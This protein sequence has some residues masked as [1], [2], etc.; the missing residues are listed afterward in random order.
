M[1]ESRVD[2]IDLNFGC[3]VR[4]IISKGGGAAV[5][6][7]PKL[8]ASLVGACT[9]AANG[10]VPVTVKMR[11]GLKNNKPTFLEAGI[12][13]Q[14]AGAS[15]VALHARTAEQLYEPPVQWDAIAELANRLSIPVLGNGDV[16]ECWDALRL[17]RSTGASGVVIGRG[18]LGRPWLFRELA[19]I[20]LG[21]EPEAAPNLVQ[22]L[23]M[24]H[25][26]LKALSL[27]LRNDHVAILQM[28]RL[29]PLYLYGFSSAILLQKQ[30]MQAKT[31]REWEECTES[32][33][34]YHLEPFPYK[35]LRYPR[36]K[37]G[38]LQG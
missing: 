27:W 6:E 11:L 31:M 23:S 34:F 30:L 25:R 9:K 24:A 5:P 36:L 32:D 2:H 29:I 33:T 19:S 4:K 10:Q 22:V 14:D 15:W 12:A 28:R 17:M 38:A 13:A 3:P 20:F 35:A 21:K 8:F 26:H 1:Q 18:C 37:G 7:D 16:L